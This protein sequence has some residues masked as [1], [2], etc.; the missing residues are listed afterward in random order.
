MS[1]TNVVE[2]LAE[3]RVLE[4]AQ[5]MISSRDL[6]HAEFMR[7]SMQADSGDLV[8]VRVVDLRQAELW[9]DLATGLLNPVNGRVSILDNDLSE[10]DRET[11]NWLRGRIGRVFSRGNWMDRLSLLDNILLPARH[12]TERDYAEL[13][14]EASALA[15]AFDMPGIPLTMPD[16]VPRIDLQR[17]AC[18]RAF[19][20]DPLLIILE[21]PTY[22]AHAEL[23]KPLV[24]AIR[25]ARDRRAAV[26]WFS[27]SQ[28]VW[29]DRS[30]PATRRY[31]LAG[32]ELMEVEGR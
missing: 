31:R 26:V 14:A 32:N 3:H 28:D 24:E 17:A 7:G 29:R 18:V 25:V 13:K 5:V 22:G 15:A 11:G 20:G 23:L 6:A 4:I 16:R 9:A 12:H 19:L 2:R 21:D 10:L 8:L 30:I 27:P 1:A